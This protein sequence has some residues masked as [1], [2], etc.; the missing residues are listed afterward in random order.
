MFRAIRA[1]LAPYNYIHGAYPPDPTKDS[2]SG[3]GILTDGSTADTV[4]AYVDIY[5]NQ[6]VSTTNYGIGLAAGHD[7]VAYQNRIVSS[8]LLPDGSSL[9]GQNVG[10]YVWNFNKQTGGAFANDVIRDNTIG[11]AK[12]NNGHNDTWF[13][14]CPQD[15]NNA[16]LCTNNQALPD[17]ITLDTE[18]AEYSSLQQKVASAGVTIGS[19]TAATTTSFSSGFKSSDPQPAWTNTV[20]SAGYPAGGSKNV[21]GIC[22]GLGPEAKNTSEQAHTGSASLLYSGTDNDTTSSYAYM[23]VFDLTSKNITVTSHCPS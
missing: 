14:D 2:F 1:K 3:G 23:Q 21:G 6:V 17:P 22:C 11:W 5:S 15:A 4:T 9:A 8:G 7:N 12:P 16:S 13:P 20:D 18:Q 19:A 10:A